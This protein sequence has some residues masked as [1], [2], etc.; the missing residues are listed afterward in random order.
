[1]CLP[2]SILPLFTVDATVSHRNQVVFLQPS[3]QHF[4][5]SVHKVSVCSCSMFVFI[6]A[7]TI[8]PVNGTIAYVLYIRLPKL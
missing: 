4:E 5:G 3:Q 1:M 8:R 2:Y 7:V 6:N